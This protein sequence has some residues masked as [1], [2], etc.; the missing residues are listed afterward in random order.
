M[1]HLVEW[2]E[3]EDKDRLRRTVMEWGYPRWIDDDEARTQTGH[4]CIASSCDG[5]I[6]E[7]KQRWA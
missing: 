2:G 7:T 6:V 4:S 3:P 1:E 5:A